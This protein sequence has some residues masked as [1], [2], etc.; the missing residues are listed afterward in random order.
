[1]KPIEFYVDTEEV[2]D[3]LDRRDLG[4][5]GQ[6]RV[7]LFPHKEMLPTLTKVREAPPVQ[8]AFD[9]CVCGHKRFEHIYHTGA[10]RP[11]F[12]C[13]QSCEEFKSGPEPECYSCKAGCSSVCQCNC[14]R[15]VKRV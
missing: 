12:K 5:S 15:K 13:V 14:H 7:W 10:C 1:M 11:G 2:K 6:I 8:D 9:A 4:D 3:C